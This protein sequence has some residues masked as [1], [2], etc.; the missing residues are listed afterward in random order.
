M[1]SNGHDDPSCLVIKL[2]KIAKLAYVLPS[3]NETWKW[4]T[5]WLLVSL[6]G[7]THSFIN[8]QL[9]KLSIHLLPSVRNLFSVS[10]GVTYP[11]IRFAKT[12]PLGVQNHWLD[13][14]SLG[15]DS[16]RKAGPPFVQPFDIQGL[17]WG[18]WFMYYTSEFQISHSYF[19]KLPFS[20]WVS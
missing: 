17:I 3:I 18:L 12:I 4:P 6:N 15:T 20:N 10:K 1:I 13:N 2:K 5:L 16:F 7:F 8:T 9:H 11:F 19:C 14:E